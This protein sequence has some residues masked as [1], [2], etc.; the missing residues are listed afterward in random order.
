MIR[1]P[2]RSTRSEFYSRRSFVVFLGG[3]VPEIDHGNEWYR[4]STSNGYE[5]SKSELFGQSHERVLLEKTEFCDQG[6]RCQKNNPENGSHPLLASLYVPR[7][8]KLLKIDGNLIISSVLAS[9]KAIT[10]TSSESKSSETT[11]S[12]GKG[13]KETSLAIFRSLTVPKLGS[14][15]GSK[16]H[17]YSI[18]NKYQ[19][20]LPPNFME[21]YNDNVSSIPADGPVKEWF[22]EAGEGSEGP[23]F[24]SGM[25]TEVFRFDA[26]PASGGMI[27]ASSITNSSKEK[28]HNVSHSH[29]MKMKNRRFLHSIPLNKTDEDMANSS[30]TGSKPGTTMVVSVLVDPREAVDDG[31]GMMQP[32]PISRIFVVVLVDS[33]RYVT[34]S[35]TLPFKSVSSSHL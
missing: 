31:D 21:R 14:E 4:K 13:D 3:F 33:V 17:T 28:A 27:L 34:Y 9:E 5:N 24:N 15:A 20:A 1:R 10:H 23:I 19:K 16:S 8:D 6:V 7:N 18:P 32:K 25:C 30:Y 29:P 22:H 35:C 26:T 12:S 11:L 2:P